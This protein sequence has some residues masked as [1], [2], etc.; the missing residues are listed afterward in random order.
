MYMYCVL[1]RIRPQLELVTSRAEVTVLCLSPK[2]Y[3]GIILS[4]VGCYL[5]T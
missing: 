5:C 3:A 2:N 1:R 4:T